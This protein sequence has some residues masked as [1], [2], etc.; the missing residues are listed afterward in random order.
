MTAVTARAPPAQD[1]YQ[2]PCEPL[3]TI[4]HLAVSRQISRGVPPITVLT[5]TIITT[6]TS[7]TGRDLQLSRGRRARCVRTV[8]RPAGRVLE[9]P[10]NIHCEFVAE[11]ALVQGNGGKKRLNGQLGCKGSGLSVI[12]RQRTP[13]H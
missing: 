6:V 12:N 2:A 11:A 7:T 5:S 10:W 1:H 3:W 13:L 4:T 8:R 9:T